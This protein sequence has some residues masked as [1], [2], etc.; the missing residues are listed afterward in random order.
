MGGDLPGCWIHSKASRLAGMRVHVS[1][2][3][4]SSP[5]DAFVRVAANKHDV[6]MLACQLLLNKRHELLDRR[7]YSL[8]HQAGCRISLDLCIRV[9]S[10]VLLGWTVPA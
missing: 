1:S 7:L 9:L 10:A 2:E 4:C 3:A 5:P 8:C 6:S